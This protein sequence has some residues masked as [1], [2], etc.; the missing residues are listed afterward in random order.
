MCFGVR[1]QV[2]APVPVR[3]MTPGPDTDASPCNSIDST[4][5]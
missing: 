2:D 4:P 3:P 5:N 1:R